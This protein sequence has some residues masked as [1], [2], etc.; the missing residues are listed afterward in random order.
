M[1]QDAE[2]ILFTEAEIARRVRELG[3]RITQDYAQAGQLLVVG[4]LKGAAVFMSDLIREIKLP[5]QIDYMLVSSY[6]NSASSSGKITIKKDLSVPIAGLN[7]LLVEDIVDTGNTLHFLLDYL[8]QREPASLKICTFLD[9]PSRRL[10]PVKAAY[11]GFVI[12]D[13]RFI[14]GYGLDYAEQYRNLPY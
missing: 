11:T 8:G 13:D 9:K 7:V 12:E 6:A 1:H 10:A 4:I 14:V 5:L 2:S 3:Q